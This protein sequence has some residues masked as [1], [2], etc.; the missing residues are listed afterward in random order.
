MSSST[1]Y[2][3]VIPIYGNE[4]NLPDLFIALENLAKQI[5]PDFEVV[6]VVDGSPDNCFAI[7]QERLADLPFAA[8]LIAHSRNFGAFTAVRTG[9]E[10]AK[11]EFVAAMAADLQ[12]PPELIT[13]FFQKLADDEADVVFGKRESREDPPLRRFLANTYWSLYRK[14]VI[15]EIPHGGVDVFACN[16]KVLDVILAIHEPNSSLISQLFWVGFRREFVP[17]SRRERVL[18]KSAWGIGKRLR[19]MLDSIFSYSDLPIL[20]V[21]WLGAMGCIITFLIGLITLFGKVV[22][23][24]DVPGYTTLILLILFFSSMLLLTQGIIGCYLWRAFENTKRRPLNVIAV[25]QDNQAS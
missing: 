23:W 17:Y 25:K 2:S 6:F 18:G 15:A 3:L 12:E 8:Q 10:N 7:L 11:G 4:L 19:Y 13:T 16:R 9:M 21:L 1:R 5:G 24:I 22:G 14:F 20:I